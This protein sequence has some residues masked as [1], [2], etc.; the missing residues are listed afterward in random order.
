M[1]IQRKL[2]INERAGRLIMKEKDL[3]Y[4][5]TKQRINA[6]MASL[7]IKKNFDEITVKNICETAEISRSGFYLHYTDKYDFVEKYQLEI[8]ARGMDI[9]KE[10]APRGRK[11]VML[12]ILRLMTAEDNV[13][14]LLLSDHGSA[15]IQNQ[16]KQLV[17]DNARQNILP[18]LKGL[19]DLNDVE[20]E[21]LLA[22]LSNAI[23]GT[24]QHWVN[25]GQK[26]T[27]EKLVAILDQFVFFDFV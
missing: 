15:T 5:R 16:I 8:M 27:P 26:E 4:H 24:L 14:A 12:E 19:P 1:D 18:H 23:F 7:L 10:V 3:R 21:Y 6:A 9:M 13:L 2:L 11:A 22:F 25:S 17:T 20:K